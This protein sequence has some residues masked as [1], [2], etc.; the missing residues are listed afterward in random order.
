MCRVIV[1]TPQKLDSRQ[2]NLLSELGSSLKDKKNTPMSSAWF[3]K[4]SSF[5]DNK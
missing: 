2:K 5:F 4:V 1:E 3:G